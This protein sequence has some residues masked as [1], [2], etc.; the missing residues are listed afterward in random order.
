MRYV[1]IPYTIERFLARAKPRQLPGVVGLCLE[2]QMSV[3]GSGY[4]IAYQNGKAH[5]AHR[6]MYEL[7]TEKALPPEVKVCHK[8]DNE[9]CIS[10]SH[11]WEGTQKQNVQDA[12]AKGRMSFQQ[13]GAT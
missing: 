1:A 3:D 7:V 8:C 10:F 11:L 12:V 2:W 6:L 9:V 13:A 4:G 5:R